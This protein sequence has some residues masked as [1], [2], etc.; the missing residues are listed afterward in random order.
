MTYGT[1]TDWIAWAAE[2]GTAIAN[3]AEASAALVRGSDYIRRVYV[4]RMASDVD[5]TDERITE[6]AYIAAGLELAEP[7]ILS[8][9]ADPSQTGKALTAVG[10]TQWTVLPGAQAGDVQV[11]IPAID[12]MLAPLLIRR[13][14][15]STV[16]S[17]VV[18]A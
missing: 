18:R 1:V 13:S 8:R 6:A 14:G 2:R 7:A 16:V 15:T 5:T 12:A 4:S 11:S 17:G 9:H 10:D 3:T